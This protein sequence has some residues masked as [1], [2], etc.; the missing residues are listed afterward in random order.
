MG[1]LV[2][3]HHM[4]SDLTCSKLA[5]ISSYNRSQTLHE[6]GIHRS[7]IYTINAYSF[8]DQIGRHRAGQ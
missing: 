1:D 2:G 6:G 3:R 4:A 8:P 7:R 5:R